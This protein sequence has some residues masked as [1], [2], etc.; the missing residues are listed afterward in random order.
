MTVR[1]SQTPFR[2]SMPALAGACPLPPKGGGGRAIS[3]DSCKPSSPSSPERF[4]LLSERRSAESLRTTLVFRSLDREREKDSTNHGRLYG[5][6]QSRCTTTG[7]IV[8][9][10]GLRGDHGASMIEIVSKANKDSAPPNE[11]CSDHSRISRSFRRFRPVTGR[12]TGYAPACGR[13]TREAP[14]ACDRSRSLRSAG[15]RSRPL[16]KLSP[17]FFFPG[18]GALSMRPS[19]HP[20]RYPPDFEPGG[21]QAR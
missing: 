18:T 16:Q 2:P 10:N 15:E 8:I 1:N 12:A 21:K 14:R 5:I 3:R 11:A 4:R 19:P 6:L 13:P 17:L 7:R 20:T 9:G